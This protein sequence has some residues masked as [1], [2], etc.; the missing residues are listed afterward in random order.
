MR[1]RI[2]PRTQT[3][4]LGLEKKLS[5]TTP[6][7]REGE[8]HPTL[9]AELYLTNRLQKRVV[10]HW[11]PHRSPLISTKLRVT[12]MALVKLNGSQ[13]LPTGRGEMRESGEERN[14][15]AIHTGIK[16]PKNCI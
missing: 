8:P 11:E 5:T 14:Q 6:G 4:D 15:N 9:T 1:C 2:L 10:I 7:G 12:V 16:L 13:N 3:D